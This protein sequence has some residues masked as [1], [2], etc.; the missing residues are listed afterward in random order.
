[1]LPNEMETGSERWGKLDVV[2]GTGDGVHRAW[3][4]AGNAFSH[5]RVKASN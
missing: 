4:L 3:S 5:S 1:M 2:D